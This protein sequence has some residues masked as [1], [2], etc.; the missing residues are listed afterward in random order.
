MKIID[1]EYD[2]EGMGREYVEAVRKAARIIFADREAYEAA[3]FFFEENRHGETVA[4]FPEEAG[5]CVYRDSPVRGYRGPGGGME[6]YALVGLTDYG[7]LSCVPTTVDLPAEEF[8]F[9]E[10][11][12]QTMFASEVPYPELPKIIA[13]LERLLDLK[14]KI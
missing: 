13:Y 12:D 10:G 11:D 2:F 14:R 8:S 7:D 4:Y 5:V 6:G 1:R 9:F 3:G